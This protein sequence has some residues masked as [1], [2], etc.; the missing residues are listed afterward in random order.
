[1]HLKLRDE[2]VRRNIEIFKIILKR[3]SHS[4]QQVEKQSEEFRAFF[5]RLNGEIRFI[6]LTSE[7]MD[8]KEWIVISLCFSLPKS[9][10]DFI[11]FEVLGGES[12]L[13]SWDG[14]RPEALSILKETVKTIQLMAKFLPY[15]QN[16]NATFR[17]LSQ[18]NLDSFLDEVPT[19]DLIHEAWSQ[20]TRE[21]SE[22]LLKKKPVGAFLF[23]QDEFA[24]ILEGQ[25]TKSHKRPMK[26][27]TLTYLD[28]MHK[29]V[30]YTLVKNKSGWTIYNDDPCLRGEVF[31]TVRAL[32]GSFDSELTAPVLNR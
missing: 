6:D 24:L 28:R 20:V 4:I 29:V 25:L 1:M 9:D 19:K 2:T 21:E 30:D 5:H 22:V 15:I 31:P 18:V 7:P 23:R 27:I 26:C 14:L 16:L 17:E 13:F 12:S 3:A 11:S 32:L 8:S 10:G